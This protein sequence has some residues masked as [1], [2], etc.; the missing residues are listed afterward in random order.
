MDFILIEV[1]F[2]YDR[3]LVNFPVVRG[4]GLF[5]VLNCLDNSDKVI[6]YKVVDSQPVPPKHFGYGPDW[7]KWVMTFT[8]EHFG[9][10]DG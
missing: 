8:Q 3:R 4:E 5:C 10:T 1:I 9:G 6:A 7:N 2:Q